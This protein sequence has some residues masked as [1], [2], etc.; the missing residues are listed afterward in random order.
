MSSLISKKKHKKFLGSNKS[1]YSI[2]KGGKITLYAAFIVKPHKESTEE[3]PDKRNYWRKDQE[4]NEK[5]PSILSVLTQVKRLKTSLHRLFLPGNVK[6]KSQSI[7]DVKKTADSSLI[8]QLFEEKNKNINVKLSFYLLKTWKQYNISESFQT[9]ED[10]VEDFVYLL[11]NELKQKLESVGNVGRLLD[12]TLEELVLYGTLDKANFLASGKKLFS[13][14]T[15]DYSVIE[16]DDQFHKSFIPGPAVDKRPEV[17]FSYPTGIVSDELA[18]LGA[19]EN[20]SMIGLPENASYPILIAGDKK[21]REII[22]CKLLEQNKRFIILDPR[23]NLEFEDRLTVPFES[24]NLG[25]N[26]FLNVLTPLLNEYVPEKLSSQYLGN[27]IDLVKLISDV[28]N[29]GAVLLRDLIDF[30]ANDYHEEQDDILFPHNETNVSLNDLYTMLTVEPG[31]LVITDYQLSIIRSLINEIRDPSI[32]TDTSVKNKKG[33][34]ELFTC[35]RVINFSSQGYKIQRLFIYSFLLQLST[36]DQISKDDEE[37]IIYIDDAELFFS[38]NTDK[39]ILAHIVKKLENS[40]FK[41]VLSTSYPSHLASQIFDLTFNRIIGNL[42]SARCVRLIS[43]SHG[44]GIN[45]VDFIRRLPKN[46]FMLLRE[47]LTEKPLLLQILPEDIERHENQ[48]IQRRVRKETEQSR[49]SE[50]D[51]EKIRL[52]YEDFAQLHP[53]MIDILAKLSSKVNRGINTESIVNIFPKWSK[54]EVKEAVSALEMFGYI[55]FETVDSKGRKNEYWTKITPR[56]KK[57]LDKLKFSKL[58]DS[59]NKEVDPSDAEKNE[60]SERMEEFIESPTVI[61]RQDQETGS[62]IIKKLKVIRKII[63]ETRDST[64]I[65]Y[66]KLEILNSFLIQVEPLLSGDYST[67]KDKLQKFLDSLQNL[68]GEDKSIESM[69]QK[70]LQQIFQKSLSIIDAI[71]IRATYGEET[72]SSKDEDFINKIIETELGSEKWKD[73][74]RDIFLTEIPELSSISRDKEQILDLLKSEFPEEVLKGLELSSNLPKDEFIDTTRKALASLLQIKTL[75]FPNME[76]TQYLDEINS[77]F[78]SSGYPEPFEKSQ[79]LLWEYSAINKRESPKSAYTQKNR[80]EII[81][82]IQEET[83]AF[84]FDTNVKNKNNLVSQLVENIRKRINNA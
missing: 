10:L 12:T 13:E 8:D 43:D 37:I 73:F 79:Q 49:I 22:T 56:G 71:Q 36:Y 3:A 15:K 24:L 20:D 76:S 58:V 40:R 54:N 38:R 27:F 34:Q 7:N 75:F 18:I 62:I 84:D 39:S 35:N 45:Q 69:P 23:M 21:T 53:I 77:F 4:L 83:N 30:Y 14:L 67:E 26:F 2:R 68:L 32:S 25:E 1:I 64:D 61:Q 66:N 48:P 63:R 44:F 72:S 57:F 65:P 55:F 81:E 19:T 82:S 46:K 60:L 50:E 80:R 11:R 59:S 52:N 41:V 51:S 78:K 6:R 31:G 74:N 17:M 42:K 5:L 29:D 16:R 28:R 47:D 70:I 9:I 33:L